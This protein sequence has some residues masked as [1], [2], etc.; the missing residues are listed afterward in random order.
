MTKRSWTIPA[1]GQP[2][3]AALLA[4]ERKYDLPHNL[5]ARVAYQESRF[6]DDI[7][8][9]ETISS[10]NAQGLMQIVPRWHPDVDPLDPWDSIDYAGLYLSK[11]YKKFGGW[12]K[13]LAAYNWGPG[14]MS[15]NIKATGDSWLQNVPGETYNY[16]TQITSDIGLA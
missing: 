11:L 1:S 15:K 4:A 7:I 12:D 6:R 14:N 13:A 8:S 5:L 2:Y 16:V 9:G 10:A 3:Q